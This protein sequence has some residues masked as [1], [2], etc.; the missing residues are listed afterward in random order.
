MGV[1]LTPN[2]F[3]DIF[4]FMSSFHH[5][6]KIIG[7]LKPKFDLFQFNNINKLLNDFG[8]NNDEIYDV[9]RYWFETENKIDLTPNNWLNYIFTLNNM[10]IGKNNFHPHSIFFIRNNHVLM[11]MDLMDKNFWFNHLT[12]W[13]FFELMNHRY[14]EISNYL[15]FWLNQT[16][17]DENCSFCG[18]IHSHEINVGDY[19]LLPITKI[20]EIQLDN[21]FNKI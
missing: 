14:D 6:E 7:L 3:F 9:Y 2:P 10:N 11:E 16:F 13:S 1:F 20:M 4:I 21:I 15:K 18:F 8:F 5:N 12:V 19:H 17:M